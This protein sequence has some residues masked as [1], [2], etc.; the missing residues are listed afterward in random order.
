MPSVKYGE[1]LGPGVLITLDG[2]EVAHAIDLY[3]MSQGVVVRGP[4]TIRCDGELFVGKVTTV[5]VDPSGFVIHEG[6]KFLG[7]GP[8]DVGV[9]DE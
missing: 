7:S 9:S 1:G 2:N 6:E 8:S 4:R 5:Y 3:L